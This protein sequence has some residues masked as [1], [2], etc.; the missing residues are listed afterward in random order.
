[1]PI[2]KQHP[3][4]DAIG[5]IITAASGDAAEGKIRLKF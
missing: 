3:W 5:V 4:R 1:M 2:Y